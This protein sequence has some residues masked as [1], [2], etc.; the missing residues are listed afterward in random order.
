MGQKPFFLFFFL[1]FVLELKT[2]IVMANKIIVS[3]IYPVVLSESFL[4]NKLLFQLLPLDSEIIP[5]HNKEITEAK[6]YARKV[7]TLVLSDKKEEDKKEDEQQI[8]DLVS[9]LKH[10]T[11]LFERE[12]WR[13]A[14]EKNKDLSNF[15][16]LLCTNLVQSDLI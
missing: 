5:F 7:N 14:R 10:L 3:H 9:M 2:K 12:R 13:E 11:F 16:Y 4:F 1:I 6:A 15:D 8:I